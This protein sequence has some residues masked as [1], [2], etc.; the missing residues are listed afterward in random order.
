M[1]YFEIGED[2]FLEVNGLLT[3]SKITNE[4]QT[5]WKVGKQGFPKGCLYHWDGSWGVV[6]LRKITDELTKRYEEQ[7]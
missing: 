2:V 5:L 1:G 6:W 7:E 3:R 4:T